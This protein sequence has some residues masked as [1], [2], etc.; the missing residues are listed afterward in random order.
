MTLEKY[1]NITDPLKADQ[2]RTNI[3]NTPDLHLTQS[4]MKI[5]TYLEQTSVK[6]MPLLQLWI[7]SSSGPPRNGWTEKSWKKFHKQL[8]K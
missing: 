6:K 8:P 7:R 4:D 1:A 3:I 5:L 2:A